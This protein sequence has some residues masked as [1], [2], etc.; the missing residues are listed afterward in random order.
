MILIDGK[1]TAAELREE[2][3]KEV[4]EFDANGNYTSKAGSDDLQNLYEELIEMVAESDE[5]LL[6]TFFEN[7]E[8]TDDE[9]KGGLTAAISNGLVPVFCCSGNK[10]I[11][12]KRIL[13]ILS[14]IQVSLS[15]KP[16]LIK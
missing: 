8:L 2:L 13:E 5:K 4:L 10:N 16:R 15:K 7:G 11:G 1:K 14:K 6:E 9:L 3:K 12:T